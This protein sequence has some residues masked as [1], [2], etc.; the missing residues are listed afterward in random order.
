MLRNSIP[1]A[2][3]ERGWVRGIK[4]NPINPYLTSPNLGRG[5]GK[6]ANS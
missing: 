4:S 1:L 6:A 5:I 2:L 3:W